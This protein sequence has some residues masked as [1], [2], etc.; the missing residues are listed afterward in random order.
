MG[1]FLEVAG[2]IFVTEHWLQNARFVCRNTLR[3]DCI[4]YTVYCVL[5]LAY[6]PGPKVCD[7]RAKDLD[8]WSTVDERVEKAEKTFFTLK[9]TVKMQWKYSLGEI[10]KD[11]VQRMR[12]PFVKTHV[13]ENG[14]NF[15]TTGVSR[16]PS[17]ERFNV[18]R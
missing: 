8:P 14:H 18:L 17:W 6:S 1:G 5:H 11:T 16:I 3:S 9:N 2:S 7:R 4:I 15:R 13:Y 10:P 12:E